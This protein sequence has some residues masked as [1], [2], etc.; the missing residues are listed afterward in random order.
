MT[1]FYFSQQHNGI[2]KPN[3]PYFPI[4]VEDTKKVVKPWT[5]YCKA[6]KYIRKHS[7]T[8]VRYNE[9]ALVT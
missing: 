2:Q 8:S 9:V 5:K 7:L 1:E 6:S 4:S 3:F